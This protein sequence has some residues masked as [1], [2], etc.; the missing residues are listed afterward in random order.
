[1]SDEE[2]QRRG[3]APRPR[4]MP[5][6]YCGAALVDPLEAPFNLA[7]I[8]HLK[9]APDCMRLFSYGMTALRNEL[10]VRLGQKPT[11]DGL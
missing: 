1:M 6:E 3:T 2:F 4:I 7:F 10:G 5:C 8:D 11:V 9:S